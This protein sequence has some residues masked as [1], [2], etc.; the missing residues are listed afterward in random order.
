ME[1]VHVTYYQCSDPDPCPHGSAMILVGWIWI[2]ILIGNE[3]PDPGRQKKTHKISKKFK[4]F[5]VL[6]CWTFSVEG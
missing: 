5:H 1:Q 3:D 4:K 6:K 2:R